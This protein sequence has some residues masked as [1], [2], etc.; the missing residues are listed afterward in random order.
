VTLIIAPKAALAPTQP[1]VGIFWRVSGVLVI[2]L[3][4]AEPYCECITH[5]AGHY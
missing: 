4:I 1:A 2:D 5:A 3:D